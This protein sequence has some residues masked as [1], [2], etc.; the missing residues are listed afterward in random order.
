MSNTVTVVVDAR[1]LCRSNTGIGTYL[2]MVLK[3]VI[4][5]EGHYQLILYSDLPI[6]NTNLKDC[7]R[8]KMR[9]VGRRGVLAKISWYFYVYIWLKI[10]SP[11]I[12]WSPRHHLPWGISKKVKCLLTIHDLIW[13]T[14]PD[15]MP[16]LKYLSER[17]LMP[18]AI[19]RSNTIVCVSDTTKRRL[20]KLYPCQASKCVTIPHGV[21]Q[22]L[23]MYDSSSVDNVYLS[24]GT[25]E[26]RKNYVALIQAFDLYASRNG[27]CDL[28]IVGA[29]GWKFEPIFD[30]W[31]DSKYRDR[32]RILTEV[33]DEELTRL[34]YSSRGYVSA[35][36]DEG[37][38]L[39]LREAQVAGLFLCISDIDVFQELFP[40][41]DIWFNPNAI[42]DIANAL[43]RFDKITTGPKKNYLSILNEYSWSN[44]ASLHHHQILKLL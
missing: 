28:V 3:E 13:V 23:G 25:L 11:D 18:R 37:Y 21:E 26:P 4:R 38:G 39:P 10:D 29:R 33:N 32:I 43:E 12:F 30:I 44:C 17:I 20:T 35:S 2:E 8:I 22:N 9:S 19:R 7:S 40:D 42:G 31:K 27:Q 6:R 15:T 36:L 41:S 14:C 1:P 5:Q 24:V 34:Y 16:L